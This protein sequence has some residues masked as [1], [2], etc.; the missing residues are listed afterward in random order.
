MNGRDLIILAGHLVQNNA[1][2]NGEARY[3]SAISR[4]YY[5]AFH[6]AVSFLANHDCK[7]VENGTGHEDAYRHLFNTN[8]DSA[9]EAARTL[10]DLRRE[11]I[12]A[13]YRLTINGLDSQKNA[14]EKVEMA[15]NVRNLLEKCN[16]EP[17][18]SQVAGA[19]KVA[20]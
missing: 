12:R 14:M 16:I 20:K 11:R 8:V 10:N 18:K 7:V 5:G 4:A 9:R 15:E 2:G 1:L 6:L 17:I 19:L 3:R 13:D